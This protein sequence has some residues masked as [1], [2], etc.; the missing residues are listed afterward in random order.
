MPYL[1]AVA[2][3]FVVGISV[4]YAI[5]RMWVFKGSLRKIHHGYLYFLSAGLLS[6]IAILTLV[7]TLVSGF[8][9]PLLI[10]RPIVSGI[11]GC[12]NYLFNL[13]LNFKVAGKH[14]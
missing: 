3:G 2:I 5:S 9:V 11:V 6:L 7:G 13:Y 14:H 8:G 10:A 4:N 12:G 1:L